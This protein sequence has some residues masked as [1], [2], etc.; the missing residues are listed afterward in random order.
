MET[1]RQI[2]S[3]SFLLILIASCVGILRP[4]LTLNRWKWAGAALAAFIM[5]GVVAPPPTPEEVVA[6]REQEVEKEAAIRAQ[7]IRDEKDDVEKAA[8][9]NREIVEKAADGVL[10]K[11]KIAFTKAEYSSE[12]MR[13]GDHIF[14]NMT[15]LENGAAYAA[16][17]SRDCDKVDIANLVVD[18]SGS[19][20]RDIS[21]PVWFVD[22]SNGNRF[23]IKNDTANSALDRFENHK[24]NYS[25]IRASC[26]TGNNDRVGESFKC[27]ST[28]AL[29]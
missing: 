11:N 1:F 12:Y 29:R 5:V 21:T 16:A 28:D 23:M 24:L 17:E 3:I 6:Q 18:E 22:C 4:Y 25:N 2:L 9:G 13:F 19:T 10:P 20:F 27:D 8:Q 26:F 14:K 7:T 15:A